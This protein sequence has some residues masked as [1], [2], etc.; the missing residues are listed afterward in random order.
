MNEKTYDCYK[1]LEP[2]SRKATI[3]DPDFNNV[4]KA[5]QDSGVV[6]NKEA[7]KARDVI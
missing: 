3:P 6:K 2:F 5:F 1:E 4:L 7:T